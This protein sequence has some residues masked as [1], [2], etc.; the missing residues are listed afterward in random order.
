MARAPVSPQALKVAREH[1]GLSQRKLARAVA[2]DLG[3]SEKDVGALRV[4]LTRIERGDEVAEVDRGLVDALATRL[5]LGAGDL[6]EAPHWTWIHLADDDRPQF[7][8]LGLRLLLYTTPE[9]AYDSRDAL[10]YALGAFD[11][12]KL[13][14]GLQD[15]QLQ[16]VF[17]SAVDETLSA[18]F[19]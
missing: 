17:R 11:G 2:A 1:G 3:Q 16:P 10:F 18:N 13:V 14:P 19:G 4:R 6:G 7:V 5:E 8:I 15:G 12:Q 9:A